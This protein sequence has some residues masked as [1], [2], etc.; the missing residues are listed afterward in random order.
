[1]YAI[2]EP[3]QFELAISFL[4]VGTDKALLFDTG[5]G[6]GDIRAVATVLT[7]R[8]VW[9]LNSHTH[10]DHVGGNYQFDQILALDTA[11]TSANAAG[12]A[13][14]EVAEFVSPGWVW[15]DFPKNFSRDSYVSKAFEITAHVADGDEIELG[16]RT[17]QVLQTP[18]HAPDA[19]CLLDRQNRLL[20]TGDSF[21]L[22]PLYAHLDGS[23]VAQYAQTAA[24]LATLADEV[25]TLVTSHNVP[26]ANSGYLAKLDAA[27]EKLATGTAEFHL[28][29]GNREYDFGEFSIIVPGP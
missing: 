6:V 16:G 27:F 10:Y 20:F 3:G 5:L 25:D 28:T 14:A 26:F 13:H 23:D 7:D 15:Q 9:V 18:G 19:L 4:I 12:R 2:Y 8:D 29:D 21:Y 11:F 1:L 24:R 17:L 22:A